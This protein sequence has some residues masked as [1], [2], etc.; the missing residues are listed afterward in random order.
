MWSLAVLPVLLAAA[1]LLAP[2][3]WLVLPSMRMDQSFAPAI[4]TAGLAAYGGPPPSPFLAG[5]PLLKVGPK[6]YLLVISPPAGVHVPDKFNGTQALLQ[7]Y[8]ENQVWFSTAVN[9]YG[10]ILFR[11]FHINNPQD[12]DGLIAGLHPDIE[13]GVYLGTTQRLRIPNT[14]FVQSA[15]EASR[16]ASIPTHIELSFSKMPPK[17]L[18]FFANE[19][20]PPPGGFTPLTD[21]AQVWDDLSPA[22][23]GSM[24]RRGLLYERWYRHEKNSNRDPLVHKTWQAMFL[25]ENRTRIVALAA[26]EGYTATWDARDDLL[27][28][29]EAIITR[30]HAE[31]GREFWSMHLNVLHANTFAVPFAWDAQIFDSKVS[32]LLSLFFHYYL[33]GRRLLGYHYGADTLYGDG[34]E[35]PFEEALHIRKVISKNTWMFPYEQGDVLMLDNHR[36]AHGRTPWFEGR[37]SVMVAYK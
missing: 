28:R 33:M 20:N 11:G 13:A 16:L 37:R 2:A 24:L 19:V 8:Y 4:G 21:F 29:H 25:T 18:Y 22:L 7:W 15:T 34:I 9:T 23:K 30:T 14:R 36:L 3:R 6:G 10:G 35:M 27:L 31:T 5:Q 1:L 12:F 32:A 17:R 26:A